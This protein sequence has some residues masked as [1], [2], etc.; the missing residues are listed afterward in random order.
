MV[1]A[2]TNKRAHP[3]RASVTRKAR[4]TTRLQ[5]ARE[6]GPSRTNARACAS[7]GS[8]GRGLVGYDLR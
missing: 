8:G 7:R 6:A 4:G 2:V 1:A 3:L 5:G